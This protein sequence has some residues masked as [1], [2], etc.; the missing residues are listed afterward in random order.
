MAKQIAAR[1][2]VSERRSAG[3][4]P[5]QGGSITGALYVAPAR[6]TSAGFR[7]GDP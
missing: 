4:R 7:A 5:G 1:V 2:I 3:R 6:H